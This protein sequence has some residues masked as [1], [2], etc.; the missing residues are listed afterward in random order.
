MTEQQR[1][2]L[3]SQKSFGSGFLSE[4]TGT[5]KA[6]DKGI[7]GS[8][9]EPFSSSSDENDAGDNAQPQTIIDDLGPTT[10]N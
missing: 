8:D 2:T 4:I 7:N 6:Q 9:G 3:F 1:K 5:K 10:R